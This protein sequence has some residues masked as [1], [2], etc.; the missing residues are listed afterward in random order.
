M[1]PLLLARM[2]TKMRTAMDRGPAVWRLSVAINRAE[3]VA[4]EPAR[5]A[6]M[7]AEPMALAP[8]AVAAKRKGQAIEPVQSVLKPT[9]MYWRV[10]LEPLSHLMALMR[11][12]S[13]PA[14]A[15]RV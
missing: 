7:R 11:P 5:A 13:R 14:R 15:A 2:M 6:R 8:V 10:V 1:H 4:Q 12:F 9:K 3:P